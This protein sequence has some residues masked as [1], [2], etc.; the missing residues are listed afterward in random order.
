MFKEFFKKAFNKE[1]DLPEEEVRK[2]N[3]EISNIKQDISLREEQ[4]KRLTLLC[5]EDSE[6]QKRYL[7]R[8]LI[9]NK[10]ILEKKQRLDILKIRLL[11]G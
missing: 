5:N 2:I 8:I 11:G 3:I 9:H 4:V 6:F 7:D 1:P 10:V